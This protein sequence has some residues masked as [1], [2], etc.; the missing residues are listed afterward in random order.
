MA[1]LGEK[2]PSSC[3]LFYLFLEDEMCF[4]FASDE[5]T[6]HIKNIK[7]NP[8]VSASIHNE[9]TEVKEIKGL[10]IRGTV[11]KATAGYEEL[12]TIKYP[13]AKEVV[14]KTIWKLSPT[15]LKY[16]DNSVGFAEKE[17]WNY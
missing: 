5:A 7:Q 17:M 8:Y 3:S 10:Q 9:T 14:N 11:S 2:T 1:T 15:A 16:T 12:Y 13:Y 4:I 6:E